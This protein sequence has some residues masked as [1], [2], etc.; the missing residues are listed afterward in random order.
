[1]LLAAER[2]AYELQTQVEQLRAAGVGLP[3]SAVA[4]D[5][6]V[7]MR[8][9][10]WHH[11]QRAVLGWRKRSLLQACALWRACLLYTSPSPRD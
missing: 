11:L 4:Q 7:R 2:D 9:R 10:A 5:V 1:M 8:A 3:S 6:V